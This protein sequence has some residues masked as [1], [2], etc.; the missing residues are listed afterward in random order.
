MTAWVLIGGGPSAW[1]IR[2]EDIEEARRAQPRWTFL[3]M[4]ARAQQLPVDVGAAVD[5]DPALALLDNPP[6]RLRLMVPDRQVTEWH[7]QG[8]RPSH[9]RPIRLHIIRQNVG[10]CGPSV[11]L[12]LIR[13]GNRRFVFVGFDGSLD[14]RTR[15]GD[16]GT[17]EQYRDCEGRM[18]RAAADAG[19]LIDSWVVDPSPGPHPLEPIAA[20]WRGTMVDLARHLA[21]ERTECA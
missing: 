16:S 5:I 13:S 3:A 6:A 11:L 10:F 4:N 12:E 19:G 17:A 15:S 21:G 14:G 8:G 2:P 18:L 1:G 20:R 7:M 9:A